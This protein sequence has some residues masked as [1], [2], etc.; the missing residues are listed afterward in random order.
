MVSTTLLS[1][2]EGTQKKSSGLSLHYELFTKQSVNLLMEMTTDSW[3]HS[4]HVTIDDFLSKALHDGSFP[5][6]SQKTLAEAGII[7]INDQYSIIVI[8]FF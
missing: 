8:Y 4:K 2:K 7:F 6:F 1:E 3:N 5:L